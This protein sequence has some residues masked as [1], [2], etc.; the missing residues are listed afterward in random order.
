[1]TGDIY[2]VLVHKCFLTHRKKGDQG[3]LFQPLAIEENLADLRIPSLILK[4]SYMRKE[5]ENKI[6]SRL[7]T[8]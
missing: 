7:I 2:A 6:T 5:R 8:A 4:V 1:M 3:L